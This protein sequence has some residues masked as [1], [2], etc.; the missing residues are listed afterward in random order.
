MYVVC[1]VCVVDMYVGMYTQG[2]VEYSKYIHNA[3]AY[4]TVYTYT[5]IHTYHIH[6]YIHIGLSWFSAVG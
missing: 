3:D 6:I 4:G 2:I 5:H 1:I